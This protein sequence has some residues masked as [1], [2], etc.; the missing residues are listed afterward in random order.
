[1]VRDD[2]LYAFV[3]VADANNKIGFMNVW[4]TNIVRKTEA[5]ID[6][7]KTLVVTYEFNSHAEQMEFK[8]CVDATW[9]RGGPFNGTSALQKVEHFKTEWLYTDGSIS[10]TA[11][12]YIDL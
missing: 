9:R 4:Q 1:M 5:L 2:T 12:F 6:S 11:N 10:S 7:N 3:N 8:S